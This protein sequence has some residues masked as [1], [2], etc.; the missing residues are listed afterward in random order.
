MQTK[1]KTVTVTGDVAVTDFAAYTTAHALPRAIIHPSSKVSLCWWLIFLAGLIAALAFIVEVFIIYFAYPST[2]YSEVKTAGVG[3][4]SVTVCNMNPLRKS[5]LPAGSDVANTFG[6]AGGNIN[7][8]TARVKFLNYTKSLNNSELQAMGH[9]LNDMVVGCTY[10]GK[11]CDLTT[12]AY[13]LPSLRFSCYF[14]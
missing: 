9:Q 7:I 8:A 4:P 10:Q 14:N 12:N 2:T 5:K 13:V 11:N 6:T 3:F 1:I